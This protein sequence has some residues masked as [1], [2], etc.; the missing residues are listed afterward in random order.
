MK[1]E[2]ITPGELHRRAVE[3][4]AYASRFALL[5]PA[6]ALYYTM[7][8]DPAIVAVEATLR[9]FA[10]RR[11]YGFGRVVFESE[12][13]TVLANLAPRSVAPLGLFV[14][15]GVDT[16]AVVLDEH[17][18]RQRL[19]RPRSADPFD[20]V[21]DGIWRVCVSMSS[22]RAF[23]TLSHA[24]QIDDLA[25]LDAERLALASFDERASAQAFALHFN[26]AGE[27]GAMSLDLDPEQHEEITQWI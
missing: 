27:V 9:T 16:L 17:T 11:G 3:A 13:H 5:D 18:P 6:M 7:Q 20:P 1:R 26:R 24:R 21:E 2:R 15:K 25:R 10:Q 12:D 14:G 4:S 22:G 19:A 23:C 8:C